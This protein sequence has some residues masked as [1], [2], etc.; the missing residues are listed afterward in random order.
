MK[1]FQLLIKPVSFDCNL[2]CK[3]C[4]YLRVVEEYPKTAHP[5]MSDKVLERII[6]QFLKFRLDESIF[7]W[8]GGE[9]TLVG[10]NFFKKAILFQQKYGNPGQVIGNALQTNGILINDEWCKFFYEYRFLVGLSLDGPKGIHNRYRKSIGDKSV[11]EKVMNAVDCFKRNN[12]E[13]NILCVISKA[14]VNRVK[15]LYNFFIDNEFFNLQFI[16]ALEADHQGK[17]TS[18]SINAAQYGNFLCNL[19][20]EWKKEPNK[21]SIRLF[22]SII[23]HYLKYPKSYCTFEKKCAEYLL[24][25]WN[26]DVYPCDFFVKNKFKLGNLLEENLS[27]IKNKRTNQFGSLKLNLSNE[28]IKCRWLE[29]CYGGC[30]KDRIFSDNQNNEKSYFC[31][32]YNTFFQYSNNWLMEYCKK[33]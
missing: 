21:A 20:D 28:C 22:N 11:W 6:S 17:K 29:L 30:I 7:G 8:Q 19:F 32:S 31:E 12:V 15:E 10:L 9:P 27:I 16:P 14:N 3:Y 25:E 4:F 33:L 5:R 24:V 18:F 26:G 2:K 13:F 1:P 23:A